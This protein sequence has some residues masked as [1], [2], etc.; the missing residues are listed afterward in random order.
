MRRVFVP[1]LCAA[2]LLA[3][4][5]A[6]NFPGP[7]PPAATE[8]PAPPETG[9]PPA[10]PTEPPAEP[11]PTPEP[12]PDPTAVLYR[13]G[14][15]YIYSLD[16]AQIEVRPAP[17]YGPYAHPNQKQVLG[18]AIYYVDSGGDSMGGSVKR[19]TAAGIVDLPF[20]TIPDMS[21]LKFAVSDDG[22]MIAWSAAD[23]GNS[24]LWVADING[25]GMQ[26]VIQS[27]PSL[28]LEDWYVLETYRWTLDNELYFAWQIS[29]IGSLE[30][31]G[32]SSMYHYRP[33]TG[34]II[35]LAE[36]PSEGGMPCWYTVSPDDVYLVGTC[37]GD[38]GISGLR[39]RD[40]GTGVENVLPLL[41]N[42][43]QTGS[44][45][46]SPS[47]VKLAY[48]FVRGGMDDKDGYLA[49][50]HNPGEAPVVIASVPGGSFHRVHWVDEDRL[51]VE[52][53]LLAGS[54]SAQLVALDG[55]M[56]QIGEGE[57]IGL[58]QP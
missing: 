33:S 28:G 52:R 13:D 14:Q 16:G 55:A 8:A 4:A 54:V 1:L 30:Y 40:V 12:P 26:V 36:A 49:V 53:W 20:T 57:L 17:G 19:V 29:G 51:A 38:S 43:D 58:M 25:G 46:Y 37:A 10:E 41:P 9:P 24:T 39:E 23:W 7:E 27:D 22:S 31:F 15:F 2:V 44:A 56:T 34:E 21:I 50:R 6:C 35:P 18:D 42:Q 5:L 11:S 47:G 48:A 3:S 45:A 32:Y